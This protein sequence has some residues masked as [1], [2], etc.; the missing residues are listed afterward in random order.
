MTVIVILLL[1]VAAL[2]CFVMAAASVNINVGRRRV[3][4]VAL[5]LACWALVQVI[6]A[7]HRR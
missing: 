4:L 7:F 3:D 1:V 2:V 5:G 6:Q